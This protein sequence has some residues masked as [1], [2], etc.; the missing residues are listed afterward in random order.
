[1]AVSIILQRSARAIV[2]AAFASIAGMP[3]PA[4]AAE[5]N[6]V[7]VVKRDIGPEDRI[8]VPGVKT[9]NQAMVLQIATA[10]AFGKEQFDKFTAQTVAMS[11]FDGMAALLSK[12]EIT[13][14][15]TSPP[16]QYLELEQP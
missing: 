5:T 12:K 9:S 15:L 8:A 10:Q 2:L 3:A 16:V 7:R 14:H 1:M 6:E 13:L 4:S 11:H